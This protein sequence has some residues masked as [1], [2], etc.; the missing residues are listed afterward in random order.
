MQTGDRGGE[1]VSRIQGRPRKEGQEHLLKSYA[2]IQGVGLPPTHPPDPPRALLGGLRRQSPPR[3]DAALPRLLA[4]PPQLDALPQPPLHEEAG[5]AAPRLS[6]F[7]GP[8]H[9]VL[10]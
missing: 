9:L 5:L 10:R 6:P 2:L 4:S 3:L 8:L 7:P 1:R